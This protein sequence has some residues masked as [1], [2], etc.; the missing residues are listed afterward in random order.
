MPI[1]VSDTSPVRA[2]D[3]LGRLDL[4][5]HL[6]ETVF[7][8]PA[9]RDELLRPRKRFRSIRIDEIPGA[10]LR[11]PSDEARVRELLE[12]LQAGEAEAIALAA[13]LGAELLIDE[14]AGRVIANE[15]GLRFTGAV[16]VLVGSKARGLIPAVMPALE[17]LRHELGFFLSPKLLEEVRRETGE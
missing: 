12:C 7:I 8:P 11:A 17:C 3:F 16:G 6:F 1:V 10:V 13:E 9:V 5:S 2:L 4:L 14:T 15:M